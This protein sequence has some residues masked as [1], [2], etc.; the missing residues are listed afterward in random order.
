MALV[1]NIA[2]FVV[3]LEME[4]LPD[5]VVERLKS[6]T[7]NGFG[8]ALGGLET[9]Y[10]KVAGKA[11]FA[12]EGE[13]SKGVTVLGDGRRTTMNGA[14]S[15]N[16][17]LFHGRA[18]E[19]TC[20]TV[21]LGAIV[22]PMLT[23]M[24]ESGDYPIERFLPALLAGYEVAG[25]FDRT[26]GSVTTPNGFR[27]STLYGTLGA[28]AAAGRMLALDEDTMAA[29]IANAASFTGGIL[30]S[31]ADGTDEW[32]YQLGIAAQSGLR[33]AQLAWAGS[34]SAPNAYEGPAGF[35][36]AFARSDCDADAIAASLGR[37]WAI[38]QVA[39]KPHPVCALN[40]TP[41]TAAVKIR[42]ELAGREPASVTVKMNNFAIG[43][44]GM[45]ET[46]PFETISD[47]LMST[48]FCVA[49]T[50]LYGEPDM[51]RMGTFDDA[52]VAN[53][54]KRIKV[55]DDPAI[56]NLMSAAIEV[57]TDDGTKLSHDRPVTALDYAY[58]QKGVASLIRRIGKEL[59]HPA[60][61]YDRLESFVEK[62]PGGNIRD[63]IDLFP[64]RA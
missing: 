61:I 52:A 30:Q 57:I 37:D 25:L 53:M 51:R 39:F 14:I 9:P 32:R 35:A 63:V 44:P 23:A 6:C 55:V 5:S 42:E 15:A 41:V 64:G 27:G 45:V 47:T 7:L 34:V 54:I 3:S 60:T 43:Y 1:H 21:H 31:F 2:K 24:L 62:L 56:D 11:A 4:E 10:Y 12:F 28:A 22:I 19:D 46:G 17:A 20:G 58:D 36:H 59:D 50:L 18:Q 49:A 26:Y 38:E 40:Q 48:P 16:T 13:T 8:I 33:A 29:A